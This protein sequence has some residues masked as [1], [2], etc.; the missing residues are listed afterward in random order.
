MMWEAQMRKLVAG[1]ALA[2]ALFFAGSQH[3]E[4]RGTDG[5][6][7]RINACSAQFEG[8]PLRDCVAGAFEKFAGALAGSNSVKSA[9][10]VARTTASGL[11]G[12]ASRAA[13]VSVLQ[14]AQS[15]INGL[16][17]QSSGSARE[18]YTIVNRA[19]SL[20]LSV[21]NGKG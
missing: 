10:P 21:I 18:N 5:A 3:A 20:A 11:R 9:S 14:R 16:A 1:L 13:A 19:F 12:A 8:K 4:A 2:G 7:R 15:V 6:I 17:A